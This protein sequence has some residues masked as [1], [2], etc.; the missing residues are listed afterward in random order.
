MTTT[1]AG[2]GDALLSAIEAIQGRLPPSGFA[3]GEFTLADIAI[4]PTVVRLSLVLE[5]E[6]GKYALG[7][8]AR[9]LAALKAPKFKRFTQYVNDL[10]AHPSIQK[11]YDEVGT[12]E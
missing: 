2:V 9:L 10:K 11:T 3:V 1:D 8:G 5:N 7:E 6:I 4:A 12:R